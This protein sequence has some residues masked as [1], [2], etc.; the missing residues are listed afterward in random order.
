MTWS[1]MS[2]NVMAFYP[3]DSF[4]RAAPPVSPLAVLP[5]PVLRRVSSPSRSRAAP[6]Q[7]VHR[8]APAS[9]AAQRQGACEHIP[10]K[11]CPLAGGGGGAGGALPRGW[12]KKCFLTAFPPSHDNI[13]SAAFFPI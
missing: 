1:R 11:A 7:P 6:P 4:P 8:C 2:S 13:I 12:G 5:Y 10:G 3:P 9:A